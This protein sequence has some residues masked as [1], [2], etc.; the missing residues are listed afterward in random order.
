MIKLSKIQEL[1]SFHKKQEPMTRGLKVSK[2]VLYDS[3]SFLDQPF[4]A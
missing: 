1:V 2:M 3:D 4:F